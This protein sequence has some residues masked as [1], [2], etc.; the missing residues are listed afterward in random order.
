M[1]DCSLERERKKN[2]NHYQKKKPLRNKP[3]RNWFQRLR[4][5]KEVRTAVTK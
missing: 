2:N 5:N 3:P 4:K 1:S